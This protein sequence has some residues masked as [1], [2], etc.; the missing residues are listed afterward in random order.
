MGSPRDDEGFTS[1]LTAKG[2]VVV[3]VGYRPGPWYRYPTAHHDAVDAVLWL[4][5]HSAEYGVDRNRTVL[6]GFSAGGL[7]ALTVPVMLWARAKEKGGEGKDAEWGMGR[8]KGIVAFYPPFGWSRTREK[9]MESNPI[10]RPRGYQSGSA[11][12][13]TGRTWDR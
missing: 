4:W 10:S 1:L 2:A 9:R 11:R 12:R 3:S 7:L 8:V 13:S 5:E 6:V